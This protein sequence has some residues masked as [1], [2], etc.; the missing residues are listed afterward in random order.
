MVALVCPLKLAVMVAE[1]LLATVP[2]VA[3]NVAMVEPLMLT[4]PGTGN[5]PLLLFRFTVAVPVGIPVNV[6]VHVV[7]WPVPNV[8]GLQLRPDSCPNPEDATR[9]SVKL[10]D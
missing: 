10:C 6:T 7:V 8:P 1:P 5:N 2:A 9:F 4:F 3:V